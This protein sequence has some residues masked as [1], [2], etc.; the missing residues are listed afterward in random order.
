MKVKMQL[1]VF[2]FMLRLFVRLF[3]SSFIPSFI[4]FMYWFILIDWLHWEW[5]PQRPMSIP[6]LTSN[7]TSTFPYAFSLV[8]IVVQAWNQGVSILFHSAFG[9]QL[10][11]NFREDRIDPVWLCIMRCSAGGWMLFLTRNVKCRDS[12]VRWGAAWT[13]VT[14]LWGVS[15]LT[16]LSLL[17]CKM[18]ENSRSYLVGLLRELSPVFKA[19]SGMCVCINPLPPSAFLLSPS[20]D[21]IFSN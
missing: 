8:E 17:I 20:P 15:S 14:T 3:M 13:L 18:G 2:L 16:C 5:N 19:V 1:E 4:H 21:N 6:P 7:Y 9:S 10:N 11:N 12:I